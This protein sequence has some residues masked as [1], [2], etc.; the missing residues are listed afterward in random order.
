MRKKIKDLDI[1]VMGLGESMTAQEK[2][3]VSAFI[4]ANRVAR[5]TVTKKKTVSKGRSAKK[6]VKK[7]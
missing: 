1:D 3:M 7:E 4:A 6:I 2:E 5:K